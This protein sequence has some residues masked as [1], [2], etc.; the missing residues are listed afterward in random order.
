MLHLSSVW[1]GPRLLGPPWGLKV[2][3]SSGQILFENCHCSMGP[4]ANGSVTFTDCADLQFHFCVL[5]GYGGAVS[6]VRSRARICDSTI[7]PEP[8]DF[9]FPPPWGYLRAGN[10]LR[11]ED[12]ELI[13]TSCDVLGAV[14]FSSPGTHALELLRSTV[15]AG[16][17]VQILAGGT[18]CGTSLCR[19]A[20]VIGQGTLVVDPRTVVVPPP[21]APG[22]TLRTEAQHDT[23]LQLVQNGHPY[24]IGADGPPNGF[25]VLAFGLPLASP[26]PTWFGELWLDPNAMLFLGAGALDAQ[27]RFRTQYS[28]PPPVVPLDLRLA[29][30]AGWL[31]PDCSFGL[32]RPT[33]FSVQWESGRAWP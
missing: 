14:E 30:Q 19:V 27:G 28:V 31:A 1:I 18:P 26:L 17:S 9:M 7:L 33:F 15:Y 20:S 5:R 3:S 8:P 29:F 4:I 32:A 11:C 21:A 25:T 23:W 22:V 10:G 2:E 12:S 13:L 16:S 24:L 6:F